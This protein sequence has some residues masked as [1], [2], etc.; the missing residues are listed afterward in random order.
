MGYKLNVKSDWTARPIC[1]SDEFLKNCE[2]QAEISGAEWIWP[3]F[4]TRG[5]LRRDFFV[6]G[7]VLSA[8]AEFICDNGFDIYFGLMHLFCL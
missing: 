6:E 7:T 5:F 8:R 2:P 3:L 4:S 1:G